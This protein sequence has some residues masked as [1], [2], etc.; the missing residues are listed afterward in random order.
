M[1]PEI[2]ALVGVAAGVR[3]SLGEMR[4]RLLSKLAAQLALPEALHTVGLLRRL[5]PPHALS[6]A[7]L[8]TVFLRNRGLHLQRARS[9]LPDA[10][11]EPVD[12]ILR[13]LELCRVHWCGPAEGETREAPR[14][15]PRR[16]SQVRRHCAVP[17]HLHGGSSALPVGRR[18]GRRANPA[19][20]SARGAARAHRDAL[21]AA[22]GGRGRVRG[23]G[24]V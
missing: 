12:H 11:E 22:A 6:E 7:H 9:A 19:W 13:Y 3:A 21:G 17:R 15:T 5:P 4:E 8:R 16:T 14:L 18:R 2:P 23:A 10:S 24:L 20:A 1:Y